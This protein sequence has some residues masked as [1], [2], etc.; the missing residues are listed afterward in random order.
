MIKAKTRARKSHRPVTPI[1]NN[2][3]FGNDSSKANVTRTQSLC[4]RTFKALC[5]RSMGAYE[6]VLSRY[7]LRWLNTV[8]AVCEY[9]SFAKSWQ[10]EGCNSQA[11]TWQVKNLLMKNFDWQ[12]K[13]DVFVVSMATW[14]LEYNLKI[15]ILLSLHKIRSL[16]FSIN[17]HTAYYN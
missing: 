6:D 10:E 3:F 11:E 14:T 7:H 16:D 9:T 12:V 4:S 17:L 1:L 5:L 2:T 13:C 15:S 8:L